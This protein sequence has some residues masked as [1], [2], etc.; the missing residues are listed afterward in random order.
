MGRSDVAIRRCWQEWGDNGRLQR[1]DGS[2]RPRVTADLEDRLIAKSAIT[3]PDSSLSTIR[4]VT[5]T[6]VST[7]TIHRRLI[8]LNLC[9]YRPLPHLS[10]TPPY[11][12]AR[13]EWCLVRLDSNHA[14]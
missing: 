2:G 3:A 13:L 5:R 8:E 4:R 10:L 6:R 14:G 1:H 9:S 7:I 12:Q 11:C